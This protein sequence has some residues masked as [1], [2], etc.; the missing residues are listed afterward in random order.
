MGCQS[1]K[2]KEQDLLKIK[3][4]NNN[5]SPKKVVF[6]MVD[7]LMYQA[8]DKGIRKQELP[9]FKYLIEH[10]Q[11]YRDLVSSFPTMSVTID[12]SLITGTYPDA[13]HVPGLNWYSTVNQK[14]IN[15]GTG[16]M[17]VLQQGIHPVMADALIHLNGSHLNKDIPTIYDDLARQGL[18]SGSINGLIYRGPSLH[19]LSIHCRYRNGCK[20]LLHCLKK[21]K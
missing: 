2:P 16:P 17:E 15:Y 18:K 10:G 6:L 11:Y 1:T 13:H 21:F 14:M 7:S 20:F 3:S 5:G 9:T 19:T 4:T 8:I 12:S